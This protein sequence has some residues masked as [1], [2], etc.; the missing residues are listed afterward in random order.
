MLH[1]IDR[2]FF[3]LILFY[4]DSGGV[5]TCTMLVSMYIAEISP[6]N[7]RGRM[8][9]L[10]QLN[11]SVGMMMSFWYALIDTNN[12]HTLKCYAKKK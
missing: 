7:I 9:A 6:L 4:S 2:F 3:Y 1:D 8:G 10:W 11:I 5:G 12:N